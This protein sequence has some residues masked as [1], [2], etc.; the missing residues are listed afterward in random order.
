MRNNGAS[1]AANIMRAANLSISCVTGGTAM[2][3]Y[4]I[5]KRNMARI[6]A[7]RK[8]RDTKTA[9][10]GMVKATIKNSIASLL[11]STQQF[12]SADG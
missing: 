10:K 8:T 12:V 6:T 1:T 7:G 4:R 11:T 2:S 9:I 3:M 5:I